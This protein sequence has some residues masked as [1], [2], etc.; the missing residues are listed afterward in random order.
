MFRLILVNY[1]V[2]GYFIILCF[3]SGRRYGNSISEIVI[4]YF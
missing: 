1:A 4:I 3:K 2:I